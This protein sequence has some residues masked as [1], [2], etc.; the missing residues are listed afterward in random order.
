MALLFLLL[1]LLLLLPALLFASLLVLFVL[2]VVVLLILIWPRAS[3]ERGAH[4]Q[5]HGGNYRDFLIRAIGVHPSHLALLRGGQL[6][7]I[8]HSC[9]GDR[10]APQARR[11][12]ARF[13]GYL[14]P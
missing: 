8:K 4:G 5:Q 3:V 1:P 14:R 12:V 2:I 6:L 10:V 9:V 13:L 11:E 7:A